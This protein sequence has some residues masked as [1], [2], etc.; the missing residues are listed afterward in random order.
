M[1]K[2]CSILL[3]NAQG[4]CNDKKDKEQGSLL[5]NTPHCRRPN[6]NL[7]KNQE[8]LPHGEVT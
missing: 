1:R 6:L 8:C 3:D 5:T 7:T 4:I 2:L